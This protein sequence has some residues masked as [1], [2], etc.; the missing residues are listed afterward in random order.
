MP[1][2][3]RITFWVVC[4]ALFAGLLVFIATSTQGELDV[5]LCVMVGLV[6]GWAVA[7]LDRDLFSDD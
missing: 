7:D 4:L 5:F 2:I 6:L 3:F 1:S